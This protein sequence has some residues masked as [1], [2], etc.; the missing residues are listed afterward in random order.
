LS[1]RK[2]SKHESI[3]VSD[4]LGADEKFELSLGRF[5]IAW[6][7]AETELYRALIQYSGVTHPVA[8]AIFSGTRAETPFRP[9]TSPSVPQKSPAPQKPSQGK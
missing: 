1:L 4:P 6:S 8:R 2:P 3:A 5:M 7:D 9:E